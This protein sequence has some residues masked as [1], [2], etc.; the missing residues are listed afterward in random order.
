MLAKINEKDP[1][2]ATSDKTHNFSLELETSGEC[3]RNSD[4][5]ENGRMY[6]R[7][8]TRNMQTLAMKIAVGAKRVCKSLI[9]KLL[10]LMETE[11]VKSLFLPKTIL[12]LDDLVKQAEAIANLGTNS[13][14]ESSYKRMPSEKSYY[15]CRSGKM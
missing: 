4:A 10:D 8:L 3:N 14:L 13:N 7:T 9:K 2:D 12:V 5:K 6:L 15:Q 11:S 1:I